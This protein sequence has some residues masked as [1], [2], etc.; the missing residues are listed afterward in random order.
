[1]N[2]QNFGVPQ[3]RERIIIVASL[4]KKFDFSTLNIYSSPSHIRDFLCQGEDFEYLDPQD[5]TLIDNP[6]KQDSGLLFVGYRNKSIRKNGVR[7][8]TEHLSR[9]HHQPNRIYSVDGIH[10]TIPSQETSGRFFVYIPEENAVRK[11]TIRECY[12]LMGFPADFQIHPRLSAAYKQVGNSVCIPMVKELALQ[13][14]IQFFVKPSLNLDFLENSESVNLQDLIHGLDDHFNFNYKTHGA[15]KLPVLAF[16]AVYQKLIEEVE[17]YKSCRLKPLGS[18]TASDR[19][20]QSAGDIE[21]LDKNG[22]LIEVIEVKQGKPIDLQILRI[23]KD[24]IIK[25]NPRRYYIF[26]SED[27]NNEMKNNLEQEVKDI[28]EVHGCQV[29]LNGTLPTLKYYLRLITAL[30]DFINAYS[31]L[32]ESDSELQAIHKLKW[33]EILNNISLISANSVFSPK[34]HLTLD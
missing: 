25:F 17:R 9:V 15:S 2:S 5:Y 31:N 29:I 21:I 34:S 27:I 22:T 8:N 14:K 20:S 26:S 4:S 33:N 3:N 11:L 1:L 30:E 18:H 10:P 24:K 12:R 13:I 23:A 7:P 32:V 28:A 16:Y 6:V 19:T